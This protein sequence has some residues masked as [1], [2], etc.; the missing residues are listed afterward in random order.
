MKDL[1]EKCLNFCFAF[2]TIRS[3]PGGGYSFPL[4]KKDGI[5]EI[6]NMAVTRKFATTV[7]FSSEQWSAL[8]PQKITAN[9]HF[10]NEY[11]VYYPD[12][13][14]FGKKADLE[15][16]LDALKDP[17]FRVELQKRPDLCKQI[18]AVHVAQQ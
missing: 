12:P 11:S 17:N 14:I 5:I 13:L 7:K 10:R 1:R 4:K 8:Y 9:H 3:V 6:E 16:I 2:P 15:T 18:V